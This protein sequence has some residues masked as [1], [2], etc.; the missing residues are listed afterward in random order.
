MC[1]VFILIGTIVFVS[2]LTI[3]LVIVLS[4]Y[5]EV[6]AKY[7]EL[8]RYLK[9]LLNVL[10]SAR[11]GNFQVKLDEGKNK[12]TKEISKNLNSLLESIFDRDTMIQEYVQKEKEINDLKED[13]LAMLTHDLKVPIIAQ[14]NTLDLLLEE[15]FGT[16]SDVQKEAIR[17]IKISNCDLR[18]L[19]ESLLESHKF[20]KKGFVPKIQENISLREFIDDIILQAKSIADL[21]NK[22]LRLYDRLEPNFKISTDVF[23]LKR[24]VQNLILNAI[25]YGINSE[26]IDITLENSDSNY[27]IRVKDWGLGISKENLDKIFNKYYSAAELYSKTGMGLGLY[28]SNK[29]VN[30]L[31]GKIDVQSE[32]NKGSEFSIVFSC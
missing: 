1:K 24:V 9:T 14:D 30:V 2:F 28:L 20:E 19:V 18:H 21:H 27:Y 3:F 25:T 17:N 29:I 5:T 13:F 4:K 15:K 32:I 8:Q 11:W 23:L 7:D 16:L 26:Y 6:A 22:T 12:L 31:G 10:S